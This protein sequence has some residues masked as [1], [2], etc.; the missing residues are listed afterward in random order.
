VVIAAEGGALRVR[1]GDSDWAARL[2]RGVA[3]PEPGSPVR[4]EA[5]DGTVLIVRPDA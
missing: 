1:L 5:V 3:M 4:V 2:P